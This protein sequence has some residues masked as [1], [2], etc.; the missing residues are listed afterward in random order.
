MAPWKHA[1]HGAFFI[2]GQQGARQ[3]A[4]RQSGPAAGPRGGGQR[5]ERLA[6]RL[7]AAD[8]RTAADRRGPAAAGGLFA[9]PGPAVRQRRGIYGA[10]LRQPGQHRSHRFFAEK[11]SQMHCRGGGV[12]GGRAHRLGGLHPA[13]CG[14]FPGAAAPVFV[15]QAP[16]P[17]H[18]PGFWLLSG[19]Q[20]PGYAADGKQKRRDRRFC[21]FA[22]KGPGGA[23]GHRGKLQPL[24]PGAPL[25]GGDSCR[26]VR[27]AALVRAVGRRQPVPQQGADGTGAPGG[28]GLGKRDRAPHI[29]LSDLRRHLPHLFPQIGS[30]RKGSRRGTGPGGLWPALRPGLGHHPPVCGARAL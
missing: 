8:R 23:G 2:I 27:H 6:G 19:E 12:P 15:H 30:D 29:G 20:H 13:G 9:A 5:R 26:P 10:V 1:F 18:V 14:F 22:G 24:H 21:G 28:G 3:R 16:K 7:L 11:C 4:R 25:P 17:G